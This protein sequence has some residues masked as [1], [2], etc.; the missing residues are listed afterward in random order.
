MYQ[1]A[2]ADLYEYM[3]N[4][5]ASHYKR[6]TSFGLEKDIRHCLTSDTANVLPLYKDGKLVKGGL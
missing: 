3:K 6:L 1:E 5:Q 4:K 2:S